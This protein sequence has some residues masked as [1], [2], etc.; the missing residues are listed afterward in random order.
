MNAACSSHRGCSRASPATPRC[1]PA[2]EY[3][4]AVGSVLVV[5]AV[6]QPP[7]VAA[8]ETGRPGGLPLP[9]RLPFPV[10]Q[11]MRKESLRT[12]SVRR[13]CAKPGAVVA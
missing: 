3:S 9:P 11:S 13:V 7:S 4:T 2:V 8:L 6:R 10:Y 5:R 1:G 12:R